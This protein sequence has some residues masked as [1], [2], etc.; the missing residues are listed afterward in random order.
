MWG[1]VSIATRSV[2][3]EDTAASGGGVATSEATQSGT[4]S[5]ASSGGTDD[6]YSPS[7][8]GSD[9]SVDGSSGETGPVTI[10]TCEPDDLGITLGVQGSSVSV[11]AGATFS[12]A[13]EDT[14]DIQCSTAWG[15]LSV[16]VLSGDQT[17]YDSTSCAD[18]DTTST[19]LLL[20]PGASWSGTLSWSG[21]VYD[22]CTALDVNGDGKTDVA[23]AGTYRVQVLLNGQRLGD[24]QVFEVR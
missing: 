21:D 2:E 19:P 20:T 5:G 24:E 23:A 8:I 14:S 6:R 22:G 3:S 17:I 16:K 13:L 10:P 18:R 7:S 12:V 1:I 11:G 15:Q 4:Q 9:G